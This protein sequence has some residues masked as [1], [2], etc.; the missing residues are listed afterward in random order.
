[1]AHPPRTNHDS[2]YQDGA[3]VT[4]SNWR[5]GLSTFVGV[6]LALT[7]AG[8]AAA[9]HMDINGHW[10]TG[11]NNH[12][13]WGI[14]HVFAVFLI[15]VASGALN[16]ASLSSVLGRAHLKP[17]ARVSVMLSVCLLAG[18]LAVLVLDLGR[19]DRLVV[20][21]TSYNF[22][23]VFTWNVFLYTGFIGIGL[24]YLWTLMD[25]VVKH[26]SRRAGV[27]ALTWRFVLTSGT[28]FIFGFLVARTATTRP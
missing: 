15:V 21:M 9:H 3:F 27:L 6:M 25:P 12:V 4:L 5:L 28:G 26:W 2:F 17:L 24:A 23:S 18:G 22:R 8:L 14:P 11:M 7:A 19:P 16:V 13:V 10:V 1:M 20:A